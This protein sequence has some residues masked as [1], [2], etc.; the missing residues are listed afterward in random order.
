MK[1]ICEIDK[2]AI[3]IYKVAANKSQN[4]LFDEM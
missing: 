1:F 2:L 3:S 4:G